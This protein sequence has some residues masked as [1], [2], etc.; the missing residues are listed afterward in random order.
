VTADPSEAALDG[1]G[2]A[3]AGEAESM[4]TVATTQAKQASLYV[5]IGIP[6]RIFNAT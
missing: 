6:F 4:P 3:P 5:R 2:A 1:T